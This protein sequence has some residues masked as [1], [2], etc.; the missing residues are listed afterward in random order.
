[1]SRSLAPDRAFTLLILILF[2]ID[3]PSGVVA[4]TGLNVSVVVSSLNQFS[5][6]V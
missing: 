3:E 2:L 5:L 4:V 1:M 6:F